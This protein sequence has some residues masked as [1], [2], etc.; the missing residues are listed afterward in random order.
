MPN[1]R[2]A[3]QRVAQAVLADPA[4]ISESSITSVARL[5]QTSETTVLRFCRAIGLAG[6]P[7]L[8]IALA[9]AAQWEESGHSGAPITGQISAT[10]SLDDVV[11]KITHADARAIED[12][13]AAIDMAVLRASVDAVVEAGRID[14]YGAAAS[15]LV[16]Q[17]L[18]HKLHRIGLVSFMWAEPQLALTSAAVLQKGDVAI[19]ISH[20]G[21]TVDTID[22]LKAARRQ[23]ATTIGITNFNGSPIT[24]ESDLLLVTAARETT[25]RSGAMSSR[26]AQLA[27]IDYLFAGVA[28]RSYDSAIQAL[29]SN[30]SAARSRHSRRGR[31]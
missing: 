23:G 4:K 1:L 15:A 29:D 25:F 3:E 17:D 6:Y 18:H 13:A 30:Y 14:I 28:Q 27:I 12:T 7:E 11:A 22:M 5:C 9:R 2:P 20:T 19:G 31:R 24:E 21:T 8:R 16:G 10:D 26:I